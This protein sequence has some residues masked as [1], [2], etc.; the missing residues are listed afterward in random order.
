MNI[1]IFLIFFLI[2]CLII[3]ILKKIKNK[4]CNR[5]KVRFNNNIKI[6]RY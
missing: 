5:K 4:Q 2:I 6:Y 3:Y 1:Y